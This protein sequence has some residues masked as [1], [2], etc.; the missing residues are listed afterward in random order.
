MILKLKASLRKAVFIHEVQ[1]AEGNILKEP[2]IELDYEIG[3]SFKFFISESDRGFA[4]SCVVSNS[5]VGN[6]G[7]AHYNVS[8]SNTSE[9]VKEIRPVI[10]SEFTAKAHEL[11][12][13]TEDYETLKREWRDARSRIIGDVSYLTPSSRLN[14]TRSN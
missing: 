7:I 10:D 1:D 8:A 3:P 6:G 14:Y 5:S 12:G 11:E 13:G 2:S 4:I 9:I